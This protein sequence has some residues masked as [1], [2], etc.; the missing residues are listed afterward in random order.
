MRTAVS[1]RVTIRN[2]ADEAGVSAATVSRVL[3]KPEMVDPETKERVR[4]A[5]ESL[6]FQPSAIA[7]GL[8]SATTDTIG[9]LVPAIQDFFFDELYLGIEKEARQNGMKV[10]LFDGQHSRSKALEGFTFLRQH[11]VDGIIFTSQLVDEDYDAVIERLGIPVVLTLIEPLGKLQI[12]SFKT[13]EVKAMFDAVSYLA[14]RG[15]QRIGLIGASLAEDGTAE[16][17]K[18]GY[19]QA[20]AHYHIP[21]DD[22][23]IEL[24]DYRYDSGY[25]AMQ[26][27]LDR[28]AENRLTA[29]C[30]V[31]DEMALGAM[32]CLQDY[33]LRVPDDM[34]VIGFDDLR[35]SR[36]VTPKLTTVAQPFADI[37]AHAVRAVLQMCR[38]PNLPKPAGVHYLPHHIVER[39]SVRAISV[40]AS[41]VHILKEVKNS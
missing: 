1:S 10:L 21:F 15:H 19:L 17:R 11:Q 23:F 28:Q 6:N 29:I 38:E 13:D 14:T 4:T 37:G 9:L 30:A 35:I 32:N 33:G 2:V 24:G 3:N 36:M 12:P 41:E 22:S 26:R 27:L 31:S 8:S 34:S 20:L 16:L 7:R 39:A 25:R 5:M 18:R 40:D